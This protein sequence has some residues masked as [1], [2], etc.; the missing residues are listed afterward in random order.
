MNSQFP[1]DTHNDLISTDDVDLAKSAKSAAG[2]QNRQARSRRSHLPSARFRPP[3]VLLLLRPASLLGPRRSFAATP[4]VLYSSNPAL[5]KSQQNT[6][7]PPSRCS[8]AHP[9]PEAPAAADL[10][11]TAKPRP[12]ALWTCLL[13]R[14]MDGGCLLCV[15]G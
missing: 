9:T 14:Q 8:A 3:P 2:V 15:S 7:L 6:S 13:C 10:L 4:P 5:T 11:F 12:G 1:A